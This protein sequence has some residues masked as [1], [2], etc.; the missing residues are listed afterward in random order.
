MSKQNSSDHVLDLS[1]YDIKVD[2]LFKKLEEV[3]VD[4]PLQVLEVSV[5]ETGS[6]GRVR[7][8]IP[9]TSVKGL[10]SSFGDVEVPC[11]FGTSL[12]P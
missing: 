4:V 5:Q 10:T 2:A 3:S 6:V 8:S 11:T 9:E 7:L 12:K 1:A